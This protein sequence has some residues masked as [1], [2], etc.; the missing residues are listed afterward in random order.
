MKKANGILV[1]GILFLTLSIG[2]AITSLEIYT[3]E[4]NQEMITQRENQMA[5]VKTTFWSGIV[6]IGIALFL[7]IKVKKNNN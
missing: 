2:Y 5:F 7:R 6:I 3:M 4:P 1:F